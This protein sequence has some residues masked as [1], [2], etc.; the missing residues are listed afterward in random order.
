MKKYYFYCCLSIAIIGFTCVSSALG[1]TS[2]T[3]YVQ[4]GGGILR[5]TSGGITLSGTIGETI[6]G[7][8]NK[9]S[10]GF[11]ASSLLP[12]D[13]HEEETIDSQTLLNAT[14][15]PLNTNTT[16]S[17]TIPTESRV[18]VK[19]TDELGRVVCTLS[20]EQSASGT[21]QLVWNGKTDSGELACA[22]AYQCLLSIKPVSGGN[23]YISRLMVMI[24]R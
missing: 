24:V 7:K 18:T 21:F 20:D 6:V 5:S 17:F 13:V 16:I 12:N 10:Q 8:F 14:P 2:L 19:I 3:R 11:W 15:N 4:A 22:G 1:Q 23:A 9:G